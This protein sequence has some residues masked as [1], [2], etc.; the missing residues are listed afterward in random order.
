LTVTFARPH[1]TDEKKTLYL[2]YQYVQH[3]L[4]PV[5]RRKERFFDK[6]QTLYTMYEQMYRNVHNSIEMELYL[7][8]KLMGFAIL[9]I[10]AQSVSAVYSVYNPNEKRRSLG[11][12]II[13]KSIE[14]AQNNQFKYYYLGYYIP[15]HKKMDYKARFKPAQIRNPKSGS[16]CDFL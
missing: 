5:N 7:K 15:G 14:W 3:F 2:N 11:T 8:D 13:L 6:E 10:A 1:V 16:W 12:A 4:K 9:D